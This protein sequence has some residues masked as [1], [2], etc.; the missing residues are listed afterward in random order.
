VDEWPEHEL[1]S[2]EHA[3]LGFY[4]SGHPLDKYAGR[5]KDLKAIELSS[6]ES[7]KNGQD[8]VV[9]AIVVQLRPMRNRQGQSWAILTLQD[10][11][12][13]IEALVFSEAYQKLAGTL[14]TATPLLVKGRV[15]IE[16]MGTRLRVSD[17]RLLDQVA[18]PPP[19]LLRVRLDLREVNAECI[20]QLK[21]LFSSRPGRCRV[22]FELVND[23]G[24]E[25]TLEASSAVRA[26]KE[27]VQR[28]REI[29]GSD[30]VAVI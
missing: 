6:M 15:A 4:I 30:S 23:D 11:T 12:G 14:K 20:D 26:D 19:S 8:I 21:S 17:A 2:S 16:D 28:V 27:L 9:A 3:T 24:S 1:L 25:A 5:L 29:C 22:A 13:E 10:R 18:D 7:C